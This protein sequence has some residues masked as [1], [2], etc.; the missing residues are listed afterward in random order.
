MPYL[1]E[2]PYAGAGGGL[3]GWPYGLCEGVGADPYGFCAG[4]CG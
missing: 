1:G 4:G 3:T 2:D